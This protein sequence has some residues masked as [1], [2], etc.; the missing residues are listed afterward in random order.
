[1]NRISRYLFFDCAQTALLALT[2]LTLLLMLPQV[3]LLVDV[4]INKGASFA[5]L[6]QLVLYAIPQFMVG[7]LPMALL[8]GT[9]LTLGRLARDSELIVMRSCGLS[10]WQLARPVGVL[11]VLFTLLSL[12][13]NWIWVPGAYYQFKV[14]KRALLSSNTMLTL[15]SRTFNRSIPGLTL[16]VEH[17]DPLSGRLDGVL[18]HDQ[19]IPNE[20]VTITARHAYPHTDPERNAALLLEEGTRHWITRSGQYR[21]MQFA[22]FNLELHLILDLVPQYHKEEID[23]LDPYELY[24]ALHSDTAEQQLAARLEWHRRLAFPMATCI[25]GLIALPLGVQQ[26]HRSGREFGVIAA[27]LILIGHFLLLSGGEALAG[28]QLVSP[29]VGL[30]LPNLIMAGLTLWTYR[31]ATFG[32]TFLELGWPRLIRRTRHKTVTTD[33]RTH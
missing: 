30:W 28:R 18:V 23:E 16:Y 5:I 19:R 26:S 21:H 3:L 15:Q 29:M 27:M 22:R 14:L 9:L 12:L 11:V 6:R 13:L 20:S 32:R 33:K 31:L 8:L 25:M 24:A 7:T 10:L 2:V 1:M 4:W 17:Q